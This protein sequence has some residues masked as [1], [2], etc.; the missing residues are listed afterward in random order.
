LVLRRMRVLRNQVFHGGTTD[1]ISLGKQSVSRA[2]QI[3]EGLL[4][5]FLSVM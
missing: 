5:A 1:R 2:V 3:L 4:P